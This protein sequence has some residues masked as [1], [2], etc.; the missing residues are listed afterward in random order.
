MALERSLSVYLTTWVFGAGA[1]PGARA[2]AGPK[3][4]VQ[5][6][7]NK[8]R[9]EPLLLVRAIRGRQQAHRRQRQWAKGFDKEC[10][11]GE[12]PEPS[13]LNWLPKCD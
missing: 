8:V 13:R 5:E 4:E 11:R 7:T 12:S 1:G 9:G 2:G 3:V 6:R 10:N